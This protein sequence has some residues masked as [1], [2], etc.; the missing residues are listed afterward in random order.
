MSVVRILYLVNVYVG[1]NTYRRA[2][3]LKSVVE[4]LDGKINIK[5]ISRKHSIGTDL[6]RFSKFL[7]NNRADIYHIFEPFLPT[8][9]VLYF[10]IKSL[11]KP[12]IY[13]SG[14]I[15]S[16]VS[17]ISGEFLLPYYPNL[18]F[19][20]S[21]AFRLSD[22]IIVMGRGMKEILEDIYQINSEKIA[23]IPDGI[24]L[25]RFFPLPSYQA[26][27]RLG[28]D[29]KFIIGY[30]SSYRPISLG[31]TKLG[32]GWELLYVAKRLVN[33]G[34]KDF[35]IIMMG[36]GKMLNLLKKIAVDLGISNFIKFTGFIPYDSDLYPLYINACDI[37]FYESVRDISYQ[38]M[39]GTK[40]LEFMACGKP[41]VAGNIG[42]ARYAL[43]HAG[44]LIEPLDLNKQQDINRYLND[45]TNA[46]IK[47]MKDENLRKKL[48]SAAREIIERYYNWDVISKRLHSLYAA[49]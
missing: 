35:L 17:K 13:D 33:I 23:W 42:E 30:T 34:H 4:S 7:A 36:K 47:L 39:I 14:D 16:A 25:S 29:S 6:L 28:L 21:V 38:A 46:I 32:R 44:I 31:R 12:I 26:K 18:K 1:S 19:S 43:R 49:L 24:D 48:G 8:F 40:M 27:E 37:G 5:L 3:K 15:H 10:F 20:E 45:L 41:M 22:R 2:F 9:P 11:R